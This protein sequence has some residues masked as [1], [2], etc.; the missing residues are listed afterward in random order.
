MSQELDAEVFETEAKRRIDS[1][2][3][4]L[5]E[6]Y[7][8]LDL[9]HRLS[10]RGLA[11][12]DP[13]ENMNFILAEA[14]EIFDAD[15]GW[16]ICAP[17]GD[18][19]FFEPVMN[20]VSKETVVTMQEALVRACLGDGKSRVLYDVKKELGLDR[21]DLPDSFLC[22]LIKTGESVYGA[23]CVGRN[24]GEDNFTAGDLKLAITM[25][26]QAAIALENGMLHRQRLEEEQA[27]IRLQEEVRIASAIQ[28]N[29]LPKDIPSP[30]GYDIAGYT[31]PASSVGGDY[32]D[33]IQCDGGQLALCLGDVSGKGMP[34]ALL[35][36]NLQAAIRGQTL[37]KASPSECLMRSNTLLYRSTDSDRFAT[38]FYGVLDTTDHCLRYA[39][40]GHDRPLLFSSNGQ[41]TDLNTSGIVLGILP[42]SAYGEETIRF[43]P[44]DSLI[45]YSDGITDA[46]D[47]GDR[48]FGL[49]RLVEVA[50]G[51]GN[52]SAA[53][54]VQ[55]ILGAVNDHVGDTP[56]TDDMTLVVVR[57]QAS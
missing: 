10:G 22:T 5:L 53:D 33:F 32:Y 44:G 4:N 52:G 36:A 34:A 39:N 48:E 8:E 14:M 17:Q 20:R 11:T 6:C 18:E 12:F 46:A 28:N 40:A 25:A 13:Q 29:L 31:L 2:T 56:Q 50:A 7:E 54:L 3:K 55:R 38:C 9:I 21:D 24:A 49:D 30:E 27:M 19:C 57:R 26:S 1:L 51:H 42:D 47:A 41:R 37:M 35:M 16:V 45:V 43:E 23:L 15:M